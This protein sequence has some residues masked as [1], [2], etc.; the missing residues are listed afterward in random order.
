MAARKRVTL[1]DY[2]FTGSATYDTPRSTSRR[3]PRSKSSG[4]GAVTDPNEKRV[5]SYLKAH[6][7]SHLDD[8]ADHIAAVV[9]GQLD[10]EDIVYR[11]LQSLAR[12]GVVRSVS[13][14]V[15]TLL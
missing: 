3:A 2:G 7:T 11:A 13:A 9:G 10:T 5:V 6:G 12:R 4:A 8:I 14:G 15:W 1:S